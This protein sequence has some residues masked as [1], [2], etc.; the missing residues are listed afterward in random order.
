MTTTATNRIANVS[1]FCESQ[2]DMKKLEDALS[3]EAAMHASLS[4]IERMLETE[5]REML[6]GDDAGALRPALGAGT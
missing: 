2:R 6:R 3:S 5:G 4:D 1:A